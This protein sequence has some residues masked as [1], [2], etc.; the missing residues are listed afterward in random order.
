[1][2][3]YWYFLRYSSSF[4]LDKPIKAA[5]AAK[6]TINADISPDASGLSME[7]QTKVVSF[8]YPDDSESSLKIELNDKEVEENLRDFERL[9]ARA[10]LA[11][12][13]Y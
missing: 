3:R 11:R 10:F 5:L 7:R 9:E 12:F 13:E 6:S 8:A 4:G 2:N 1:M